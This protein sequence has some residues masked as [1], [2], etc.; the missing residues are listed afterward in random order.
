M[1]STMSIAC[2]GEAMV[3][4]SLG[5]SIEDA[6]NIGYAGDTL[7]TA[8]Y[9]K[10]CLGE[11]VQ[12]C[13]VSALGDDPLSNRMIDFMHSESLVST[14]IERRAGRLPGLYAINTDNAGERTFSYWRSESAARSLFQQDDGLDFSVLD[15]FDILYLSAIT[16]AILPSKVR[17]ALIDKLKFLR[18]TAAKRIVF[19]S[20]F[21]PVLWENLDTARL[22]VAAAWQA[23]SIALPSIDDEMQLF[24]DAT[25][26]DVITRLRQ[27]GIRNG[28]LKRGEQG[29]FSLSEGQEQ[30]TFTSAVDKIQGVDT[31]AAGD[32]F[33]AAYLAAILD[34]RTEYE[35]LQ[36]GHG[37]ACK[38][39][40]HRGAIIPPNTQ[41]I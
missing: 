8:I 14:H 4:L 26:T 3:E 16:L 13:Y 1:N 30:K 24:G 27:Y 38:V 15:N 18:D 12:V 11:A 19:D 28:A 23:C 37:L 6:A 17:I 7:N 32:S 10:R 5:D 20:N 9:L 36:A 34:G 2:I 40:G 39:I 25:E 31:T 33:N 29:P 41:G 35:A 21:R 22:T